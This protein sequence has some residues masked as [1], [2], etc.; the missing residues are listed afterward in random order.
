[1]KKEIGILGLGSMG[2]AIALNLKKKYKMNPL[3]VTFSP[4]EYTEP[5]MKNFHNWPLYVDVHN[6]LYTPR[7]GLHRKLTE[8]AFKNL[9]HPFQPFISG[10]R[11]FASHMALAFGVPLIFM[12]ESQSEAGASKEKDEIMMPYDFWTNDNLNNILISGI[13]IEELKKKL[14]YLSK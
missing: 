3:T 8:L 9:L 6:F 5:G 13:E 1:M 14:W 7:G 2:T 10:Q 4:H 11:H 12:G